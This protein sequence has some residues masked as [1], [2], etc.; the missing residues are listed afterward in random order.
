MGDICAMS[1][2][3]SGPP[4]PED[5]ERLVEQRAVLAALHEH[6]VQ[7]PVEIS[8]APIRAASTAAMASS[9]APGPT[10]KP[11]ARSARAK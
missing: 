6:C 9:T 8:L 4:A 5:P 10:G 2:S 7:R 11:A 3:I 1:F